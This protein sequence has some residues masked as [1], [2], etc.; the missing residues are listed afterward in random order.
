M[1]LSCAPNNQL[2]PNLEATST[3]DLQIRDS[4]TFS[5]FTDVSLDFSPLE[6]EEGLVSIEVFRT[7]PNKGSS[8]IYIVYPQNN[9]P[10]INDIRLRNIDNSVFIRLKYLHQSPLIYSLAVDV[11]TLQ[12]N[13]L[14]VVK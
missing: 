4:F 9:I 2:S 8:P 3:D 12:V 14:P 5:N 13:L 1:V 10:E 11:T 6:N 7:I